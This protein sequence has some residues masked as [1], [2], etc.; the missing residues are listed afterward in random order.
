MDIKK[1][2]GGVLSVA[3]AVGGW[4]AYRHF[5]SPNND[6][7]VWGG[8]EN[9]DNKPTGSFK[10]TGG[11]VGQWDMA[12]T[13]CASGEKSHFDGVIL[14]DKADKSKHIRLVR[15][16]GGKY[17]VLAQVGADADAV[18]VPKC[19]A[20]VTIARTGANINFHDE[21]RGTA[22]LTCANLSGSATFP[23]CY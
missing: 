2:A 23:S 5:T 1:I 21:I 3:L 11:V 18:V 16:R 17:D 8:S 15:A 20:E 13:G 12:V 10:A 6:S 19:K 9:E 14:Y 7:A 4:L 22:K